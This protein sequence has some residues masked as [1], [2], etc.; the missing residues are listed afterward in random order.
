MWAVQKVLWTEMTR[1]VYSVDR[2]DEKRDDQKVGQWV[3][4]RAAHSGDLSVER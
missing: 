4:Q 3:M 2:M 1:A